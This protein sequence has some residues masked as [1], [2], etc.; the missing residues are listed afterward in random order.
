MQRILRRR[1]LKGRLK[2]LFLHDKM[3][4]SKVLE[5]V[6]EALQTNNSLFLI[7]IKI[8]VDNNIRVIVDGDEGVPLKECIRISRHIE[9]NLDREVE[10]YALEVMSAGLSE[11]FVHKR[12][13]QKNVGRTL[14][15]K[16]KDGALVEGIV[17]SVDDE[18]L[19]LSW[20][21]REAKP[22][23][24]GKITVSKNAKFAF[25]EIKEA[26]VKIIFN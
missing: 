16:L 24:K 1:Q 12:Q 11:P 10:D 8:S 19:N 13:F 18:S 3:E 14:S 4:Q 9:K 2:A 21:A 20:E 22:I 25:E 7:E 15:L 5:L 23:G 6:N 17:D 26:K